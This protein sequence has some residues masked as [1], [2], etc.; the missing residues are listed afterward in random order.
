MLDYGIV[1]LGS[2]SADTKVPC[3]VIFL[4]APDAKVASA[5]GKRFGW[6]SK[7]SSLSSQTDVQAGAAFSRPGD[8][9]R[10]F[11]AWTEIPRPPLSPSTSQH[12]HGS[13]ESAQVLRSTNSEEKNMGLDFPEDEEDAGNGDDE[14]LV[15]L[16]QWSS[17]T[18]ADRFKHP[19]QQSLGTNGEAVSA[20]LWDRHI[21][22]PVRQLQGMG[23]KVERYKL[24]L[25]SVEDR[26]EVGNNAVGARQRSG[27]RRLS[28]MATEFSD[29][30]SGLWR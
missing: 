25:R 1:S 8:L 20:D 7:K 14:S 28:S 5:I 21:A 18:D 26:L 2:S 24:E 23:A 6:V 11:W 9:I 27:S 29:R 4:K 10:D 22:N 19:L 3:D 12:S 16:F 15:M 13:Y 30:L 17:H